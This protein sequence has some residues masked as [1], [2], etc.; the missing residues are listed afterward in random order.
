M[1]AGETTNM[2]VWFAGGL[3]GA[4]RIAEVTSASEETTQD[5]LPRDYVNA[6]DDVIFGGY[7]KLGFAKFSGNAVNNYTYAA[8]YSN[9]VALSNVSAEFQLDAVNLYKDD[10]FVMTYYIVDELGAETRK[11]S[12]AFLQKT[13]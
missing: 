4:M 12:A 10:T 11:I 5:F 1:Q 2:V 3:S 7:N 6:S 8:S 9:D 13:R